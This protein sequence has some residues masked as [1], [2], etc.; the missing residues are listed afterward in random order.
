MIRTIINCYNN[1]DAVLDALMD[2]LTGRCPFTG[3]SP[4]DP[5]CGMWGAEL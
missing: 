3:I 4:V 5:F 1:S 2:K